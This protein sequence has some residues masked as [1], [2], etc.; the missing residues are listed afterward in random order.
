[1]RYFWLFLWIALQATLFIVKFTTIFAKSGLISLALAKSFAILIDINTAL[2]LLLASRLVNSV[3]RSLGLSKIMPLDMMISYHKHVAKHVFMAVIGH[4]ICHTGFDLVVVGSFT[5][6][7]ALNA[8]LTTPV[9]SLHPYLYWTFVSLPGWTGW[10]AIILG[11]IFSYCTMKKIRRKYFELF[12]YTHK[13]WIPMLSLTVAH[14]QLA[15]F[16]MP[17]FQWWIIGPAAILLFDKVYVICMQL[18]ST[19]LKIINLEFLESGVIELKLQKPRGFVYSTGQYA[20]INIPKISPFQWHPFS[21]SSSPKDPFVSFHIAPAGDWTG[22]LKKLAIENKEAKTPMDQMPG[23]FLQGGYG[24]PSQH[25]GRY[26]HI[27]IITTGVGATPFSSILR[28]LNQKASDPDSKYKTSS[29]D[30]FWV[31]RKPTSHTWMNSV[32]HDVQADSKIKNIVNINVFLTSLQ[33][34]YDLRSLFLWRGLAILTSKGRSI[35]GLDHFSVVH[36]GRPNWNQIFRKKRE[37]YPKGTSVGVFFC[38]A[39]ELGVKMYQVC[40]KNSGNVVF[41]FHKEVF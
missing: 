32:L 9:S 13:F 25:Y 36:W 15:L 4:T 40:Q 5:D 14:G 27:I 37:D 10:T 24:A 35:K 1:V 2:V 18:C 23:V 30:F 8:L 29:V 11:L 17:Q 7:N 41:N 22:A 33:A 34:K 28:R 21:L 19:P 12:W 6:L 20:L 38:G 26:R 39:K 16:G 3:L 31:N